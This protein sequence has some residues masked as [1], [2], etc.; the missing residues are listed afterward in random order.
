MNNFSFMSCIAPNWDFD[1]LAAAASELSYQ[2]LEF[3]VGANQKHGI[4][5]DAP[6]SL[7]KERQGHLT[8]LNLQVACLASSIFFSPNLTAQPQ[9]DILNQVIA[10][11]RLAAEFGA[12]LIR[13]SA[14]AFSDETELASLVEALRLAGE[15]AAPY[16]VTLALETTGGLTSARKV[17]TVLEKVG[18]LNVGALWDVYHTTRSGETLAESY[19]LLK[20]YLRHLHLNQLT[21]PRRV[22][23]LSQPAP[24]VDY[25]ALFK[26][27][28][29]GNFNGF[30]SGEWLGVPE[31]LAFE[32]L[33]NYR[34][35]LGGWLEDAK[36]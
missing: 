12:P 14:R 20:P 19:G 21:T 29:A 16:G 1:R 36:V 8:G 31:P 10:H 30:V 15:A 24:P 3:R 23:T 5:I 2:G 34:Q 11:S 22:L 9:P 25:P 6:A 27:L 28:Q 33:K 7:I 18:L 17:Q 35:L 13:V 4:E 32:L 26:L